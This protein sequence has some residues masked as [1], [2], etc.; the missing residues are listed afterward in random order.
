MKPAAR[1]V[2]KPAAKRTRRAAQ[3]KLAPLV[4]A[5][6]LA[7]ARAAGIDTQ[8]ILEQALAAAV[9]AADKAAAETPTR[10]TTEQRRWLAENQKAIAWYNAF[11]DEHGVFS[12]QYRM[13]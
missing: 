3:S 8:V 11:V 1:Q 7:R 2:S 12:E 10:F 5:E 13:F 6:L 4:G 9:A